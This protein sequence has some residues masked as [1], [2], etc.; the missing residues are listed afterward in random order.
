MPTQK[1]T[2]S[3]NHY[4]QV[5]KYWSIIE[6]LN[7]Q[8][9]PKGGAMDDYARAYVIKSETDLL[10]WHHEHAHQ[11]LAVTDKNKWAYT[12]Y[13]GD[14]SLEESFSTILK[15]FKSSNLGIIVF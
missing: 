3:I 14:A 8:G 11:A 7:P 1:S 5:L 10:P 12:L 9:P 15:T 6:T 4:E 13:A 2:E